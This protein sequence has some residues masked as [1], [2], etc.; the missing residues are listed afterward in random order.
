MAFPN[1]RSDTYNTIHNKNIRIII[2]KYIWTNNY[3]F[4]PSEF[5][6]IRVIKIDGLINYLK[7][8]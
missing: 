3:Y 2:Y 7:S 1:R 8:N 5:R 4:D 6:D